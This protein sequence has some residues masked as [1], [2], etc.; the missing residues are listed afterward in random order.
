MEYN[1]NTIKK[2]YHGENLVNMTVSTGDTGIPAHLSSWAYDDYGKMTSVVVKD[3]DIP[4]YWQSGNK[5]LSSVTIPNTVTS[6]GRYAFS[7]LG[8]Y[9]YGSSSNSYYF[10]VSN[11]DLSGIN[12]NYSSFVYV[13]HNSCLKGEITIPNSIMT[14]CDSGYTSCAMD[15]FYQIGTSK[16]EP[17]T[18]NVYANNSIMPRNFV[19][20]DAGKVG[21]DSGTTV[22]VYGTPTFLSGQAFGN[23]K[24]GSSVIFHNCTTPPNAPAYDT[25]YNAPF[26]S[27]NGTIYVPSA[28]LTAW[29]NKYTG[30]ADKIQA[31]PT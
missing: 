27:F 9:T 28:G 19:Y 7:E 30:V 23:F 15:M 11:I 3:G 18:I 13:F 21:V 16:T 8:N 22:N 17:L 10:D 25:S 20:G 1:S 4:A 26:Y 2:L 31:I 24:T 14:Q 29:K 6:I 5:A 12:K